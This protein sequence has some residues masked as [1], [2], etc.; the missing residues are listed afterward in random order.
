[1]LGVLFT[2]LSVL[3]H[4]IAQGVSFLGSLLIFLT[5]VFYPPPD[6]WPGSLTM[7]LNPVSPVLDTTRSWL[8]TGSAD[9][10]AGFLVVSLVSAAALFF[11]WILYRL[12]LPILIERMSA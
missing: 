7:V 6:A 8:L 4:D 10:L 5:P 11:S 1:V 9:H 12:A 3:Y 2:P